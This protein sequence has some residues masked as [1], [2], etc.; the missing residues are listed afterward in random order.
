[1]K[2]RFAPAVPIVA[3]AIVLAFATVSASTAV[4]ATC[5]DSNA[6]NELVLA[7][8]SGQTTQLGSP[9]SSPLQVE[10]ANTNG[11]PVTG[12]LAGVNIDFVA[13]AGGA[14]GTFASTGSTTAVV[15]TDAQGVATA[16]PFTAN[17]AAG[18]YTVH[19][20]SDYGTVRLYLANTASGLAAS[21]TA[22]GAA[23]RQATVNGSY[24]QPLQ[25]R[26]TDADGHAVQ[27]AT[28][29]FAFATGPYG[30]G[31]SFLTGGAQATETTGSDGIA[32]SPL[33]TANGSPGRFTATASTGGLATV[34]G[35]SLDN[36]A[37]ANTL[38]A[39][40]PT[41][42]SAT[43][44]SRYPGPLAARLLDPDGQPIE[45]AG[46]TF[47]LGSAAASGGGGAGAGA[48]FLG[49]SGQATV[50]TDANGEA[51]SPPILANATAGDFT[52]A[53]TVAGI[54][55]PLTYALHNL[56]ARLAAAG[57]TRS[58]IVEHRFRQRLR[59]LVRGADGKPLDG[60]TVAFVIGTSPGGAGAGFPDGTGQATA[61][62]SS[63]GVATAPPLTANST[64]GSFTA[65]APLPGSTP[66]RFTL[67][68]RAGQPAAIAAGAAD[69]TSTTLGTRLPIRLAVT[70]TD[71]NGNP[72]PGARVRFTAP[73]RGP[74]GHFVRTP[75][76]H[77]PGRIARV[78]TNAKGI[79]IAPPF[80][81]NDTAGGYAVG[82]RTGS[83]RAAFALVNRP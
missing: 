7:G 71:E 20:E 12:N 16:P 52:A 31:A 54:T 13:P 47:T 46:V 59:V 75:T 79:A 56:P 66:I 44:A 19:A 10:L 5:P 37:A 40:G 29:S 2:T 25:V 51:V 30:A 45:G 67:R 63:A 74:G 1:V 64:A 26:V 53:A 33:F 80:I 14:S 36:H 9:F 73:G 70:V 27:G 48:S 49:G 21:I 68:N 43:I 35:F 15:G 18:S 62:T 50:L 78:R 8:G 55:A 38:G 83:R 22:T 72:V 32:T 6:P 60:V 17:D 58:A 65:T 4:A 82:V 42:R 77:S 76:E 23:S 39:A 28:V 24:Q 3:L 81:A 41:T 69:G 57:L 34:A 61:T 11:C